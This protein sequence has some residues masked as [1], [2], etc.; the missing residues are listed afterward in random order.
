MLAFFSLYFCAEMTWMP[1]GIHA[2][3][4]FAPVCHRRCRARFRV[5]LGSATEPKWGD[6]GTIA[7]E[8]RTIP[9]QNAVSVACL[10][11]VI[12][13][14]AYCSF[15]AALH[16]VTDFCFRLS[17]LLA[18]S[19]ERR[20]LE[21]LLLCS[22]DV[23]IESHRAFEFSSSW[24]VVHHKHLDFVWSK[25]HI[26]L[27]DLLAGLKLSSRCRIRFVAINSEMTNQE[28]NV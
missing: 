20:N 24:C 25:C 18:C 7:P 11:F 8:S 26:S 1:V 19:Q 6:R 4:L 23:S 21:V 17:P 16:L 22:F 9:F 12:I 3:F 27:S 13:R 15:H 28:K 5:P 2:D 10:P 14:T